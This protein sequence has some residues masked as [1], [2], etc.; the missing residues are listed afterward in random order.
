M[1]IHQSNVNFRKLIQ[2]LA[3]MYNFPVPEVVLTELVANSLDAG[4]GTIKISYDPQRRLLIVEDNG[5]GMTKAQFDEYHD[6]AAELKSRGE[7]IGFAGLGA[8]ISFNVASRVVTET[9]GSRFEGGSNWY[10]KSSK[11]LVWEELPKIRKHKGIGTRVEVWFNEDIGVPYEDADEL[12]SILLRQYLP[13]FDEKALTF[14]AKMKRYP[15][16]LSFLVNGNRIETFEIEKKFSLEKPKRIF[17]EA[18]GKRYGFGCF[19]LAPGEYVLGEDT[20]GIGI[21][22]YGKVVQFNFFN[23]FPGE[24]APRIVGM[25]EIPPFIKFLNTSKS[26]FKRHRSTVAEFKSYYEPARQQFKQWLSDIGLKPEETIN[27]E[28]AIK[29]EQEIKKLAS[30]IPELYQFFGTSSRKDIKVKNPKGDIKV[31]LVEGTEETFPYGAGQGKGMEGLADVG[32]EPGQA[33]EER[34]EGQERAA[35]ISRTRRAGVRISFVNEPERPE[36]ARLDGSIVFI[37]VGHQCYAKVKSNNLARRL[38]NVFAIAVCLERE[39]KEEGIL[40]QRESF[41]DRIMSAWGNIR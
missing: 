18:K 33:F 38:H 23:Q 25:V 16:D 34:A 11:E 28:E 41:I 29:L 32:N 4:A 24:M 13:L 12:I 37:N 40:E 21:C 27:S 5:S 8:K 2:D 30:E 36:L 14:Y 31:T 19:G 35:P 15:R 9:R 39:L 3:D 10:L 7:G 26:G 17:L 20:A 22:V 1:T 6:F